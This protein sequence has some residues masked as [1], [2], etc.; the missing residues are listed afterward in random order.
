MEL[1]IPESL[2]SLELE[3]EEPHKQLYKGIKEG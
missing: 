3:H 2:E 1:R